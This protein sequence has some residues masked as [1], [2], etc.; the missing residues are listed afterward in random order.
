MIYTDYTRY[1][2][3][4]SKDHLPVVFVEAIALIAWDQGSIA[5]SYIGMLGFCG[6]GITT[7]ASVS[8]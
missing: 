8:E 7:G 1:K 4:S 6:G 5:R 2:M 3:F